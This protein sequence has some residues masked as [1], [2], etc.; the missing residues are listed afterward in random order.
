MFV[1]A[2]IMII[3]MLYCSMIE[4]IIVVLYYLVEVIATLVY[5]F[6]SGTYSYTCFICLC[7]TYIIANVPAYSFVVLL[8]FYGSH[9]L[10]YC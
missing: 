8:L 10:Y 5:D 6:M 4:P 1:A 7:C 3:R 2:I 9:L